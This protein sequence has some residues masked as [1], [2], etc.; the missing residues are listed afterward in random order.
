MTLCCLFMPGK[1]GMII[2]LMV[3]A[4]SFSQKM[5]KHRRDIALPSSSTTNRTFV[6]LGSFCSFFLQHFAFITLPVIFIILPLIHICFILD[7]LFTPTCWEFLLPNTSCPVP[8]SRFN[9]S[10]FLFFPVFCIK[11]KWKKLRSGVKQLCKSQEG[12]RHREECH[13]CA[14]T[15]KQIQFCSNNSH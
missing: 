8:I 10:V 1:K 6:H 4:C 13:Y 3:K 9:T 11:G 12:N 15:S 7:S 5:S 2:W 14:E